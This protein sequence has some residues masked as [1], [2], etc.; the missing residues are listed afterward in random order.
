MNNEKSIKQMNKAELLSMISDLEERLKNI[1]DINQDHEKI[2]SKCHDSV[3]NDN[4]L[5]SVLKKKDDSNV[6]K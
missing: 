2:Y 3:K 6:A 4:D 5:H 1:K